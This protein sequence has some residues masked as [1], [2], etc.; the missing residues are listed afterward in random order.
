M[1]N[2]TKALLGGVA[3]C[4]LV[5]VPAVSEN[6][7]SFHMTALHGGR[8]INKTRMANPGGTHVTSSVTVFTYVPFSGQHKQT[9]FASYYRW[10]SNSDPCTPPKIKIGQNKTQ[11]GKLS[12]STETYTITGCQNGPAKRDLIN[13]KITDPNAQGKTD[14][15]QAR[16]V[17]RYESG[18]KKY[19]GTLNM[20]LNIIIQ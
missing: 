7:D 20:N 3:L 9:L 12:V 10:N 5:T 16:F 17:G 6:A 4:A 11:Y 8:V 19:K 14:F 13:Y 15:G 18:G 1:N 2:L